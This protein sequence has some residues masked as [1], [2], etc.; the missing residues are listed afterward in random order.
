MPDE[1]LDK[2]GPA[3]ILLARCFG[4]LCFSLSSRVF[5]LRQ[6]AQIQVLIKYSDF[7]GFEAIS[8]NHCGER[9]L[10]IFFV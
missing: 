7:V 3:L 1:S 10:K 6:L 5:Q 4:S 9:H 8:E 2:I